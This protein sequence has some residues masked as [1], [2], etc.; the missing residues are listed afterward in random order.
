M[1]LINLRCVKICKVAPIDTLS[2]IRQRGRSTEHT[3]AQAKRAL[4]ASLTFDQA[5][6]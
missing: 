2:L 4:F 1:H 5:L 6:A 3:N